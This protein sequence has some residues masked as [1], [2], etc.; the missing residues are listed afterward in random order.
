MKVEDDRVREVAQYITLLDFD[1]RLAL[2]R[3]ECVWKGCICEGVC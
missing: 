2:F 1:T 3:W